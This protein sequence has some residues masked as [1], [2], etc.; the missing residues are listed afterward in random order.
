MQQ[1][2]GA[3]VHFAPYH[4]PLA[5]AIIAL[6]VTQLDQPHICDILGMPRP[7]GCTEC[8]PTSPDPVV[9]DLMLAARAQWGAPTPHQ[10]RYHLTLL[11]SPRWPP[12][13]VELKPAARVCSGLTSH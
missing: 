11:P 4:S 10:V 5:L 3:V 9:V 2:P 8:A 1:Q 7:S 6:S 13:M 12:L